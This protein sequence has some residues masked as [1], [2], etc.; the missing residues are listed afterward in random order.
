MRRTLDQ[1]RTEGRL[2]L[3]D[4]ADVDYNGSCL[5]IGCPN[6]G[7]A[8]LGAMCKVH[9]RQW[10]M[11]GSPS[12]DRQVPW[13]L[14]QAHAGPIALT[15][16]PILQQLK[17]IVRGCKRDQFA[18]CLCSAHEIRWRRDGKP[19]RHRFKAWRDKQEAMADHIKKHSPSNRKKSA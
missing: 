18:R 7:H 16:P 8:K 14:D 11:D 3:T 17:C 2:M 10:V 6:A 5:V 1:I 19:V 4:L 15:E 9:H 13:L 12:F